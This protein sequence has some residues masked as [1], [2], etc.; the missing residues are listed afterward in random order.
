MCCHV[1]I[2]K[3]A[4]IMNHKG[5]RKVVAVSMITAVKIQLS[6]DNSRSI[7]SLS[8][9]EHLFMVNMDGNL[10]TECFQKP[11]IVMV[12]MKV[13]YSMNAAMVIL[14]AASLLVAM[15]CFYTLLA[16]ECADISNTEQISSCLLY[17]HLKVCL[18]F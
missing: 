7:S 9:Y 5:S 6:L 16:Y 3:F 15:P 8:R 17:A 12:P 11:S 2:I 4:P 18:Q 14:I 13:T 10:K 1:I